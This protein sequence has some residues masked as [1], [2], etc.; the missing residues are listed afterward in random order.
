MR[1]IVAILAAAPVLLSHAAALADTAVSVPTFSL[2]ISSYSAENQWTGDS[3]NPS[4]SVLA[5]SKTATVIS[6]D[7]F[8]DALHVAN[9]TDGGGGG[10]PWLATVMSTFSL[11]AAAGYRITGVAFS[12]STYAIH[13]RPPVPSNVDAHYGAHYNYAW[14]GAAIAAP[15]AS[16]PLPELYDVAGFTS[17]VNVGWN[18]SNTAGLG[19]LDLSMALGGGV[20]TDPTYYS[21]DGGPDG[22]R[23]AYGTTEL[24]YVNPVLTVYTAALPVPEPDAWAMLG[25]GLV[26]LGALRR[27]KR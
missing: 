18:L 7:S 27:R 22:E 25:G 6:L 19:N 20:R 21:L 26:V 1:S 5:T 24:Y 14:A 4:I 9:G 10:G 12:A 23:K 2:G 8:K 17:P 16:V 13:T 11:Q 15:G 3:S